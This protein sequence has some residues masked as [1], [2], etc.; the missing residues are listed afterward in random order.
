MKK[1]YL[2]IPLLLF[3]LLPLKTSADYVTI[4]EQIAL[5]DEMYEL[6]M[7]AIAVHAEAG[8]QSFE[9]RQAVAG[10]I[11]NRMD[12]TRFPN[13][14]SEVLHQKNQFSVM[15]D[16]GY[17]KACWEV[18]QTDYD[19]VAAELYERRYRDAL[20]FRTGHYHEGRTPLYRIGAHYFSK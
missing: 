18:E 12:S 14:I 10:V 13:T 2:L 8:N 15:T 17:E 9:G 7:L 4:E 20:F 6:E 19:A 11:L 5:E 3:C 1:L 16:G